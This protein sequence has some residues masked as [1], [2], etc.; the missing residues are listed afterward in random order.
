MLSWNSGVDHEGLPQA[1]LPG[2]EALRLTQTAG[3][4]RD[5]GIA[6][7]I[8]VLFEV[9]KQ[10]RSGVTALH[11]HGRGHALCHKLKNGSFNDADWRSLLPDNLLQAFHG[12]WGKQSLSRFSAHACRDVLNDEHLSLLL[13][14]IGDFLFLKGFFP[15]FMAHSLNTSGELTL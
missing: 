13:K 2:C 1:A 10:A 3:R 9:P 15:R 14:Y 5:E 4:G 11:L 12:F 7:S 8:T 6:P